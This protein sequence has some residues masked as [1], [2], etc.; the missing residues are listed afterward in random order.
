MSKERVENICKSLGRIRRRRSL[1]REGRDSN[2]LSTETTLIKSTRS[3]YKNESKKEDSL[4]KRG[5]PPIQ[6]WG[7]K[8][9]HMYKDFPHRG[10]KMNTMHNIQEATTVEDMG[11]SIPRIYAALEDRQEE[12]QSHMIEVEGKI[13]NHPVVF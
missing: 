9:D 1:I 3:V 7:C 8:E 10:D 4:G 2:L 6:C 12:Y 11:R 5:R 13:I